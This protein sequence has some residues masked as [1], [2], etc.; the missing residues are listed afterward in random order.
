MGH[1]LD[2]QTNS[3]AQ[4]LS[5]GWHPPT[6]TGV[7]EPGVPDQGRPMDSGATHTQ[8][9]GTG[10]GKCSLLPAA[11]PGLGKR[12]TARASAGQCIGVLASH[13]PDGTLVPLSPLLLGAQYFS[14]DTK[15]LCTTTTQGWPA[16]HSSV[17]EVTN[18][19]Q[20]TAEPE[21]GWRDAPGRGAAV[22]GRVPSWQ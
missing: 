11:C 8:E 14:V 21:R 5:R 12:K 17:R 22:A 7:T 9:S 15:R 1:G 4:V 3:T 2:G 19:V 6:Q 13:N 16:F 18:P 10:F 20:G